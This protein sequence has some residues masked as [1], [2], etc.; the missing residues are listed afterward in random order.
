MIFDG[1]DNTDLDLA[2][3]ISSINGNVKSP[4]KVWLLL[5]TLH[6]DAL[7]GRTA[8]L[9]TNLPRT[10]RMQRRNSDPSVALS[11]SLLLVFA[12]ENDLFIGQQLTKSQVSTST[13]MAKS[14]TQWTIE[15][16]T[17]RLKLQPIPCTY[18]G[19]NGRL[20]AGQSAVYFTGKRYFLEHV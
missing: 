16:A 17:G 8:S 5:L 1:V 14:V 2:K 4:E 19:V 3:R 6:N 13:S 18:I 11:G 12:S 15:M 7:L 9:S 10:P 20:Y